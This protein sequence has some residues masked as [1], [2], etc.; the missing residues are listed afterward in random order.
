VRDGSWK[1][2]HT[3]KNWRQQMG[4]TVFESKTLNGNLSPW[5]SEFKQDLNNIPE[6]VN[7]IHAQASKHFGL[8]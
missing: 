6:I 5:V 1:L 3:T 8:T 2:G 4:P 7:N